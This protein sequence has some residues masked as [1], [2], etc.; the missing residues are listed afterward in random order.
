M[1]NGVPCSLGPREPEACER[2]KRTPHSP[3]PRGSPA[4]PLAPFAR[5]SDTT[6]LSAHYCPVFT[7]AQC[8]LFTPSRWAG[9]THAL[10]VDEEGGHELE[11]L[12]RRRTRLLAP[13]QGSVPLYAHLG[14]TP[15][16]RSTHTLVP[17]YT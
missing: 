13:Y 10:G 7:T 8:S 2:Q 12:Q 15:Q 11:A 14:T 17:Q 6:L 9:S 16:D 1:Q 5:N 3:N 4:K